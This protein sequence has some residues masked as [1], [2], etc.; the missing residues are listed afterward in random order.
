MPQHPE[1]PFAALDATMT[2]HQHRQDALIEILHE[3]QS[4][5]GHLPADVLSHVAR[6]LELPPSRVQGVA[7]FYHLFTLRPP[8]PHCCIVCTGTAC[9]VEGADGL[10]AAAEGSAHAGIAVQT[11]RCIGACGIAPAVVYDG[12]AAGRQSPESVS[13]RLGGWR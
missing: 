3:A 13:A 6:A 9:F 5:F 10:L 11:T 7:T 8:A 2:R 12:D 1:A 4:L